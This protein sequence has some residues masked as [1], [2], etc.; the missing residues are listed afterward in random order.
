M[1]F[2]LNMYYLSIQTKSSHR[3]MNLCFNS[4]NYLLNLQ[5]EYKSVEYKMFIIS[6]S[7]I[8]FYENRS[9]YI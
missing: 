6:H 5:S 2:V 9:A 1:V 8:Q 3:Y 4:A 7:Q